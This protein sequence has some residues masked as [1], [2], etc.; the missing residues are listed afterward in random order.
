[1]HSYICLV[2]AVCS[3]AIR[4]Q[5][6]PRKRLYGCALAHM[7]RLPLHM[8]RLALLLS[9]VAALVAHAAFSGGL[10]YLSLSLSASCWMLG[11]IEAEA[12]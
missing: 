7:C 6:L 8:C 5:T 1:M 11:L 2:V 3:R 12:A 9:G 4:F 10:L